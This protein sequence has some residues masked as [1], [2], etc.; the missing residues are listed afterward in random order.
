LSGHVLE[1]DVAP[2]LHLL[3]I[4]LGDEFVDPVEEIDVDLNTRNAHTTVT[5]RSAL[6][7]RQKRERERNRAPRTAGEANRL[8][9]LLLAQL[10]RPTLAEIERFVATLRVGEA[11]LTQ[12]TAGLV[13]VRGGVCGGTC[14]CVC[15]CVRSFVEG[16]GIPTLNCRL[17][18]LG[19][20]AA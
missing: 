14:V 9:A 8:N 2:V 6:Q 7:Q 3:P 4:L 15:V 10:L 12:D 20:N 18:K 17:E 11:T 19:S 13:C 16:D 1:N 5:D